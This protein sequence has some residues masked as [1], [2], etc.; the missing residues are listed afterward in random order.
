M[1]VAKA[2]DGVVVEHA[3]GLHQGITNR[4][5]N[6]LE[7]A[8]EQVAAQRVGFVCARGDFLD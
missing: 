2:I 3:D 1:P 5:A 8:L 6:E 4:R 7:S